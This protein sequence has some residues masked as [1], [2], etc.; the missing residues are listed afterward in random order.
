MNLT[1]LNV[2]D[3]DLWKNWLYT[4]F[5]DLGVVSTGVGR[6]GKCLPNEIF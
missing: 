2:G 3:N 1:L 6:V 5:Q 4:V